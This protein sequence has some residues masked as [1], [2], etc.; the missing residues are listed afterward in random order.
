MELGSCA[1]LEEFQLDQMTT[2]M[3]LDDHTAARQVDD[4]RRL[5]SG[6]Q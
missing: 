3:L 1:A 2:P 4:F 6:A 5:T